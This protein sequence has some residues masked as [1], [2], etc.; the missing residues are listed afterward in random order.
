MATREAVVWKLSLEG[1]SPS[2]PQHCEWVRC[3]ELRGR[4]GCVLS[5]CKILSNTPNP[6]G[7]Q[8]Q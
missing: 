5:V 4:A 2:C 3:L 1:V 7:K 6:G 8:A